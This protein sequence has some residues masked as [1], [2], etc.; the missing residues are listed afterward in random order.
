M[1]QSKDKLTKS[2]MMTKDKEQIILAI[3]SGEDKGKQAGFI[4]WKSSGI[5]RG[6]CEH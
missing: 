2:K 4:F 5:Q 3:I 1:K 6:V